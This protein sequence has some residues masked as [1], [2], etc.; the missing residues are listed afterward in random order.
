VIVCAS[1]TAPNDRLHLDCRKVIAERTLGLSA[2]DARV[3]PAPR[4]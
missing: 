1:P 4:D 2:G 3:L